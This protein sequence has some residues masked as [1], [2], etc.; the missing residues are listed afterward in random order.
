MNNVEV[1]VSYLA[2]LFGAMVGVSDDR[3]EDQPGFAG[4]GS[5]EQLDIL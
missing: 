1:I 5:W 2:L 4:S 3:D